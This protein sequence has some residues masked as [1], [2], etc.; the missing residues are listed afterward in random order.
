MGE[1]VNNSWESVKHE[2]IMKCLKK[3]GISNALDGLK[4]MY[5]LRQ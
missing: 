2:T 5:C 1:W 4:M 3:C